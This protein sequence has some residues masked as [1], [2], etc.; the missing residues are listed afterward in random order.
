M[1][2]IRLIAVFLLLA[3]AP[4]MAQDAPLDQQLPPRA[5]PTRH[6]EVGQ[7]ASMDT[8]PAFDPAARRRQRYLARVNG[9]ARARSDAY[10]EGG[11]WLKLVDLIYGLGVAAAAAVVASLAAHP[12]LGGGTHPQPQLPGDALCRLLCAHRHHRD[13]AAGILRRLFPRA[14]LWPV[15]PEHSCNGWAISASTSPSPWSPALIFLPLLYAAIRRARETWWL[16]GA[17]LAIVFKIIARGDLARLHRAAVQPLFAPARQPAEDSRSCRWRAPM[18]F[19]RTM[20]G[21]WMPRA[22]PTASR[23]MSRAFWAPPA[24]R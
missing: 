23:P 3:A 4:A 16:W 10:F 6:V 22:S 21:W 15:Q 7:L 12:R 18:T 9:A 13:P 8:T 11:Y 24:F 5:A 14:C 2:F 20:S 19:P 1:S 17:G